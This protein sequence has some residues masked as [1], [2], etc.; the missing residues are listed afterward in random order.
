MKLGL[1]PLR[2]SWVVDLPA[3]GDRDVRLDAGQFA[4]VEV[5]VRDEST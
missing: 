2:R 4:E 3:A 1:F 5:E